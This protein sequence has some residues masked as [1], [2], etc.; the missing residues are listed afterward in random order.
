MRAKPIDRNSEITPGP[1]NYNIRNEKEL[2]VPSYKFGHDKK[3]G[4]EYDNARYVPGP[5][6]YEYDDR[7]YSKYYDKYTDRYEKKKSFDK[8]VANND[9]IA[10]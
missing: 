8:S 7:K 4:L 1:G 9:V 6:N 5:G 10:T 3:R 2:Q